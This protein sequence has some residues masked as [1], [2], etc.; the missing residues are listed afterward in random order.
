MHRPTLITLGASM[1]LVACSHDRVGSD[2]PQPDQAEASSVADDTPIDDGTH[3]ARAA[4]A[5]GHVTRTELSEVDAELA[6]SRERLAAL[7][8]LDV[9]ALIVAVPMGAQNCYGPCE[10]DPAGQAWMQA[11]TRQVDR[12]H[13]LVATAEELAQE[14]TTTARWADAERAVQAL[15]ELE[16]VEIQ[17]IHHESPNCYVGLC[18]GDPKRAAVL[19]ALAESTR[20]R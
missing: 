10:D 3:T 12:F 17:S 20:A 19:V 15:A 11:H 8:I 1:A 2:A 7:E 9:G 16:I 18:P 5:D 4:L 13:D 6:E 14:T